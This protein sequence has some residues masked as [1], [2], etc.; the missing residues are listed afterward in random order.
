MYGGDHK[1]VEHAFQ[2]ANVERCGYLN[3]AASMYEAKNAI[4]AKRIGDKIQSNEQWNDNCEN[5]M[6]EII[7]N[8]CVQVKKFRE[9]LRSVAKGAIFVESTY[10]D[11]WGS[12]LNKQEL[13]IQRSPPGQVKIYW[14][15]SYR[16][17]RKNQKEE[18]E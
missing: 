4:A 1:S 9:K 8:K 14:G 17:W 11:K 18:K 16:K 3:A 15:K 10:N 7:E 2:Y 12:G 5:V 13:R 6:T